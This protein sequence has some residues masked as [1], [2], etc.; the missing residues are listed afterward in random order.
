[1]DVF[2]AADIMI[3]SMED[4]AEALSPVSPVSP[5]SPDVG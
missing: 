2:T 4:I 5:L 3:T 1:L